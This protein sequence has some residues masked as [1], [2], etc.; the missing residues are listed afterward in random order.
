[1]SAIAQILI[2]KGTKVTGSDCSDSHIISNLKAAGVHIT[3][4]HYAKNID[5]A[6]LVV[7]T[8]AI[9]KDNPELLYAR[10]LG[11]PTVERADCLGELMKSYEIPIAIS[12]TH[13]KTT[14]TAM[15]SCVLIHADLNPTIL[16]GGEYPL[17]GGN[18]RLGGSKYFIF[19]AC[20]YVDSFLKFNPFGAIVLN[21][22]TDHLD[23]F[24]NIDSI[25]TSF[26]KFIN[27][28]PA[29]GFIVLNSEDEN[30]IKSAR[31]RNKNKIFFGA[32]G[33][34]SATDINILSDGTTEFTVYRERIHLNVKGLH[35]VSNALAV[36]ATAHKIGIS[37]T[38]IKE[39]IESFTGIKR[40]FEYIGKVNG[41]FI[42]DDYAHHPTEMITTLKTA[43][44]MPHNKIWCVFQPHTYT[45]TKALLE[46]F[47]SALS[48][49]DNVILIK[50][51]A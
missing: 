39:G 43:E 8:A 49:C 23:Y 3:I 17:I 38:I 32:K 4:G 48:M 47:A 35:N 18:L 1:M 11:I 41:A 15:L 13:G 36:F 12:G 26:E 27:K 20:E 31:G 7:Y 19:E 24:K 40:R 28:V 14:T 30:V 25:I 45:R 44:K 34:Y 33:E 10:K 50:I 2:S 46:E 9:A 21:I 29:D 37:P 6:D 51:Y 22:E 42:Y 16:V 5:S